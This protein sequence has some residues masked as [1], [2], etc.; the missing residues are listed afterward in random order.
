MRSHSATTEQP[1]HHDES[2]SRRTPV[3]KSARDTKEKRQWALTVPGASHHAWGAAAL[4]L[5]HVS[6]QQK[7]D[8]NF[9]ACSPCTWVEGPEMWPTV[10]TPTQWGSLHVVWLLGSL[11]ECG[12]ASVPSWLAEHET[13]TTERTPGTSDPRVSSCFVPAPHETRLDSHA[14]LDYGSCRR[15]VCGNGGLEAFAHACWR[16]DSSHCEMGS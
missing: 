5:G 7:L 2:H 10:R 12:L 8:L 13:H 3:K 4:V 15:R 1:E 16:T 11:R 6:A 9:E 14:E